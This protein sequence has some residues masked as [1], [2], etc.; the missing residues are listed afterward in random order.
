MDEEQVVEAEERVIK[1]T[2]SKEARELL[3]DMSHDLGKTFG[4]V[5]D[6]ALKGMAQETG[7]VALRDA[8]ERLKASIEWPKEWPADEGWPTKRDILAAAAKKGRVA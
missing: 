5:V 2:V 3:G 8:K 6:Q 4:E 7:Y 1:V